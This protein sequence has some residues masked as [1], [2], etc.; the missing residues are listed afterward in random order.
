[1]VDG[2]KGGKGQKAGHGQRAEAVKAAD[3]VRAAKRSARP[4]WS[5]GLTQSRP[6][7]SRP[8]HV[9]SVPDS[10]SHATRTSRTWSKHGSNGAFVKMTLVKISVKMTLVKIEMRAPRH[11]HQPH[12]VETKMVKIKMSGRNQDGQS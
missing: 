6:A 4:Q 10:R 2:Q 1:M 5:N 11:P 8:A 9:K 12:L 3:M 7:S